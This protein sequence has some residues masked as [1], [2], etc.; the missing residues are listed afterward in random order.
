MS[1]KLKDAA[2]EEHT[3]D[4]EKLKIPSIVEG[5]HEIFTKGEVQY[6]VLT[7][8][9]SSDIGK[10]KEILPGSNYSA[11]RK[12]IVGLNLTTQQ[13]TAPSDWSFTVD[14]SSIWVE[15]PYG[16]YE[17]GVKTSYSFPDG[18]AG[19]FRKISTM[20]F[21]AQNFEEPL[22]PIVEDTINGKETMPLGL[23]FTIDEDM[24]LIW[25]DATATLDMVN[26][27]AV[28]TLIGTKGSAGGVI[29]VKITWTYSVSGDN[30]TYN[31]V[32]DKFEVNG[33]DRKSEITEATSV[34]VVA[35]AT[36]DFI[37]LIGG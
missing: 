24:Q 7:T 2:G 32:V 37:D 17:K 19:A 30:V 6:S 10:Q 28:V 35:F 9:G 5:E 31:L 34:K 25:F 4:K 33:V 36:L 23:G 18:V 26:Q 27:V 3:Y 8:L 1:F 29:D 20:L 21:V 22:M 11:M 15:G 14:G 13:P 16:Y 12:C